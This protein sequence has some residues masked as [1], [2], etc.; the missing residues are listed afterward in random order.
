MGVQQMAFGG[1]QLAYQ[2][3]GNGPKT[4][5][6]IHGGGLNHQMWETQVDY[7]SKHYQVITY[8]L[9][10]HGQ[11]SHD[12]NEGLDMDDLLAILHTSGVQNFT[13]VGC[14]LGSIIALDLALAYPQ[15]VDNLVLVS[16]GLVG[17]QE[18]NHEYLEVLGEYIGYL[19]KQH[20][21]QAKRILKQLSFYGPH[22]WQVNNIV[23]DFYVEQC[24]TH[25]LE[26]GQFARIPQL[27]EFAP[28]THISSIKCPL[29]L[30]YGKLDYGYIHENVQ[31]IE[32]L[33]PHA[34]TFEI[35]LAAHLPSLEQPEEFNSTL[36]AFI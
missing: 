11:S 35:D 25:F 36:A 4:L 31:K 33:A 21:Q 28:L 32:S 24:L 10:G 17:F 29:L 13:L 5:V 26:S 2:V 8:D 12:N 22:R 34:E 20:F 27:K 30:V 14:S 1:N 19:E 7:F 23:T 9:R 16:P 18:R 15:K 6:F 3:L